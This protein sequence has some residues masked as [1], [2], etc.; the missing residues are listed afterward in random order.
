MKQRFYNVTL[1]CKLNYVFGLEWKHDDQLS[2]N[3]SQ[4]R[5]SSLIELQKVVKHIN[6]YENRV[7]CS[8]TAHILSIFVTD[9][10]EFTEQRGS[11]FSIRVEKD[12]FEQGSH[13]VEV[14]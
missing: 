9:S 2:H 7:C 4:F 14:V 11:C 3:I 5:D 13:Q 12:I 8:L 10:I 6:I 1:L